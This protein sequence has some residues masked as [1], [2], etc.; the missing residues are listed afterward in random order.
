MDSLRVRWRGDAT[1]LET[2]R[3]LGRIYLSQGRYREA[4]ALK[5]LGRFD[6][7]LE[8]LGKDASPDARDLRGEIAWKQ[9]AWPA[10]GQAIEGSL[11]DRWKSNLPL[12]AD[13]ESRLIR[14]GAAYSLAGDNAA[15]ARLRSRFGKFG[16]SARQPEAIKVALTGGEAGAGLTAQDFAR[17][18]TDADALAGW[19]DRMKKRFRDRPAPTAEGVTVKSASANG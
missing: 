4:R 16:G 1:E 10:A 2:I 18:V 13:E 9:Q 15:L 19:V 12:N 3:T 7:A 11:G 6:H 8:V 5:D 17:T 14:A